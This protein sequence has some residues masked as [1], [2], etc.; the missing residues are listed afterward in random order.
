[1]VIEQNAIKSKFSV[2]AATGSKYPWKIVFQKLS[3]SEA[4][5]LLL[6]LQE[7][8]GPRRKLGAFQYQDDDRWCIAVRSTVLREDMSWMRGF[9][10]GFLDARD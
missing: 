2:R 7:A 3:G 4:R 10:A 5:R 9:C 8:C 1:M 6:A